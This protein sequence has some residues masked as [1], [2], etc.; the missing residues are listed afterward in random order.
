MLENKIEVLAS[1]LCTNSVVVLFHQSVLYYQMVCRLLSR[2][3]ACR[4]CIDMLECSQIMPC[5]LNM[6]V[7]RETCSDE[8]PGGVK[9]IC[10]PAGCRLV[11]ACLRYIS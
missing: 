1:V 4:H 5:A 11:D 7:L 3:P 2:E 6:V 10:L 8:I 9:V